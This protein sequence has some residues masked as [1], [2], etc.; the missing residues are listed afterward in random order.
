MKEL[1]VHRTGRFA[2]AASLIA[3]VAGLAL[4]ASPVLAGAPRQSDLL[5]YIPGNGSATEVVNSSSG[6]VS[7]GVTFAAGVAG[8]AFSLDG[9]GAI[10]FP[11]DAWQYPSGS[12]SVMG[13]VRTSVDSGSQIVWEE[14]ECAGFC[15]N[16]QAS[17]MWRIG[18]NNGLAEGVVREDGVTTAG[19]TIDGGS[20]ADG[21][22]H[23]LALVRDVGAGEL[24][25]YVDGALSTAAAL[26]VSADGPLANSDGDADPTVVGAHIL[27]GTSNLEQFLTGR[28]DELGFYDTAL[29]ADDVA[30]LYALGQAGLGLTNGS[31]V[32]A[33]DSATVV[34]G[35][36]ANAID[37]LANDTDPDGNALS[38]SG[39]TAAAHGT[40]TCDAASCSYS[41]DAGYVGSDAFTYDV[42]DGGSTDTGT[43][44]ITV[45]AAGTSPAP[46][47]R[48]TPRPTALPTPPVT[49]T[50]SPPDG[51]PGSGLPWPAL[52]LLA[53]IL[54]AAAISLRGRRPR[55]RAD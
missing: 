31:P 29:S 53:S 10:E 32:A 6:S 2:P 41:P 47:A 55:Q 30:A 12:F 9:N 39:S 27:G 21:S 23:H 26:D 7:G 33:D 18:V 48:T 20:V 50:G 46:T 3:L 44:T 38:I 4:A 24:S 13:W 45:T 52:G 22:W 19:Q 28:I 11:T 37:V 1:H 43:V 54:A 34:E 5:A 35:S 49:A 42:T 17:S 25:L 15:P 51:A 36:S 8:Q 16:A 40:A 14:Y